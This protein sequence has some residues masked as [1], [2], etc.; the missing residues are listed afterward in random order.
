MPNQLFNALG[1]NRAV[2]SQLS[3]F[4]QE[5][6]DFQ[7][8]F[9]GNPKDEVQKLMNEGKLS[10]SQFNAYAQMANQIMNAMNGKI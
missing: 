9:N 4:I 2:N 10:Q 7:K 5:I 1:G 6:K 8:N 3:N